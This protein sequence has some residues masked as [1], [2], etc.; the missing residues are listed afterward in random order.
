V[1]AIACLGFCL[2]AG[3]AAAEQPRDSRPV[4]VLLQLRGS[5]T[6]NTEE[7]G[8]LEDLILSALD[9][10][11]RFRVIGRSDIQSMLDFDA[12]KQ[13]S[14]C[15]D[16]GCMTQ[17]AG[18]L[19]ADYVATAGVGRLGSARVLTLKVINAHSGF[20]LVHAREVVQSDEDL[21]RAVDSV[22]AQ[23]SDA[24][25]HEPGAHPAAVAAASPPVTR[26]ASEPAA[27]PAA[28][29]VFVATPAPAP[30][31]ATLPPEVTRAAPGLKP[32][33]VWG[34][35]ALGGAAAVAAGSIAF[36]NVAATSHDHRFEAVD[37][38]PVVGYAIAGA[39]LG[40]GIYEVLPR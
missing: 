19:G 32:R 37:V 38:L 16:T 18:A 40:T 14:G 3:A 30:S 27:K 25:S 2:F 35:V 33:Q 20:G 22:A 39:L 29:N 4:L 34:I 13:A 10:T 5:N 23:T 21:V 24:M 7:L 15:D 36:D 17:I 31:R 28:P 26:P 6:F 9:H 12:R 11:G 8:S 1:P